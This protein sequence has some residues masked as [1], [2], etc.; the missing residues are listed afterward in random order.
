V[1]KRRE[2]L[3]GWGMKFVRRFIFERVAEE[4]L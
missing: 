1:I 2:F 4:V 3:I